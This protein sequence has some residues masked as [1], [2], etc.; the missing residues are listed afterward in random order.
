MAVD[1]AP[2]GSRCEL[3]PACPMT[4]A[5][6]TDLPVAH[7]LAAAAEQA[8]ELVG[9]DPGAAKALAEETLIKERA[10]RNPQVRSRAYRAL[11]LA[12]QAT[13]DVDQAHDFLRRAVA[14]AARARAPHLAAEARMSLSLVLLDLGHPHR[15][16]RQSA[17]AADVLT[18]LPRLRLQAQ[19]ALV[20]QRCG[21]ASE[22]LALYAR[23]IPELHSAGDAVWEANARCNRGIQHVF[24][25]DVLCAERDFDAARRLYQ[26]LGRSLDAAAML[27]NLGCLARDR[28]DVLQALALFDQAD[29]VCNEHH[30]LVG[31]R[32]MDRAALLLSVGVC[33]EA[34]ELA[35]RARATFRT[36]RQAVDHLEAE[37]LLAQIEIADRRPEAALS[38]AVTA[39]RMATRQ[40]RRN[41]ALHAKRL[42]LLAATMG[43]DCPPRASIRA[44]RLAEDLSAAR[45]RDAAA[46]ARLTA[47]LLALRERR[48]KRAAHL[49]KLAEKDLGQRP[50]TALA[51]RRWQVTALF[52]EQS[53]DPG[54]A[55]RAVGSGMRALADHRAMLGASDLS[56]HVPVLGAELAEVGLRLAVETGNPA[57]IWN[58]VER[59]RG[60]DLRARP[61]RPPADP[62]LGAALGQLRRAAAELAASAHA[63]PKARHRAQQA[64]RSA[65]QEVVRRSRRISAG[66]SRQLRA[67]TISALGSSLRD[68]TLLQYVS[69]E[70]QLL[71]LVL[72]SGAKKVELQP[73]GQ[74]APVRRLVEHLQFALA[75]LAPGRGTTRSLELALAGARQAAAQLDSLLLQPLG[76]LLDAP[77]LVI[78]PSEALTGIP[79]SVLA[80][81]RNRPVHIVRSGSAW[82]FARSRVGLRGASGRAVAISGPGVTAAPHDSR[83]LE[84]MGPQAT[85]RNALEILDGAQLAHIAA[86]GVFSAANPWLSSLQLADGSLTV[87]DFQTLSQAP[88]Y[89]VLAAC[90]SATA[91]VL[92][93]N[94]LLGFAHLLLDLGTTAVVATTLPVP[95]EQTATMMATLHREVLAGQPLAEALQRARADLDEASIAGFAT[96]AS[97]DLY[98]G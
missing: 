98:G 74:L 35:V 10:A 12:A 30:H 96:L 20:L 11:G 95:D 87:F 40:H 29:P 52:R 26:Q 63:E 16:L 1:F 53:G 3:L 31:L 76:P 25:G 92:P 56:A 36:A 37:I 64:V 5:W 90:H 89:V 18:G 60:H 71:V 82:W 59:W 27:W 48:P 57:R 39:E 55:A 77:G 13:G 24:S 38:H 47:A 61:V 97:F 17:L 72:R 54:G 4:A 19:R 85:V 21:R 28:G 43:A 15:A 86:H 84:L 9:V 66:Q 93:G 23:V 65:E 78:V 7:S 79:W 91:R 70:N 58:E 2:S 75:R 51:V 32:L 22:A 94:Q 6:T 46:E 8:L 68:R 49:L 33:Q 83:Q 41:W 73:L 69:H 34:R 88:E 45:W 42:R 80:S 62:E 67:P 50:G 81:T 44:D 14:T